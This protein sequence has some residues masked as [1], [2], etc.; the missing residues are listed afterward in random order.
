MSVPALPPV[1][2]APGDS[3]PPAVHRLAITARDEV[4]IQLS[5]D[6]GTT[7]D[8]IL[9]AG[10]DMTVEATA[11]INL[12][13]GNAGGLTLQVDDGRPFALGVSGEVRRRIFRFDRP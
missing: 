4:W 2:V 13:A 5:L 7:R 8:V 6:G 3:T 12:L 9:P 1:D 10:R 11:S